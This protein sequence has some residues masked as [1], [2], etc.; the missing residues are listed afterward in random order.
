MIDFKKLQNDVYQNKVDKGF[1]ITDINQEFCS[2][3]GEVAEAYDAWNKKKDNVGEELADIVIFTMGLSEILGIDLED[4]I[5]KKIDKNSKR[6][7]K[8]IDGVLIKIEG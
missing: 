8:T 5:V 7:Y 6:I 3:Y 1:N 4:E 2:I